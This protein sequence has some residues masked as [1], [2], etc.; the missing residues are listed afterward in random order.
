MAHNA[1]PYPPIPAGDGL[2]ALMA[3]AEH[4]RGIAGGEDVDEACAVKD[5]WVCLTA[6][7]SKVWPKEP[8]DGPVIGELDFEMAAVNLLGDDATEFRRVADGIIALDA[9]AK[10][11]TIAPPIGGFS[12]MQ[13]IMQLIPIILK[14]IEKL[15]ERKQAE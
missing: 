3:V 10:G 11:I 7:F 12:W 1:I 4:V 6:V 2:R 15:M 8:D 5:C 13:L 9:E 14:L